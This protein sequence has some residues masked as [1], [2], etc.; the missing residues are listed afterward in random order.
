MSVLLKAMKRAAAEK[1]RMEGQASGAFKD[2]KVK[3]VYK[4]AP[5]GRKR[6]MIGFLLVVLGM[7]GIFIGALALMSGMFDRRVQRD[8]VVDV[9]PPLAVMASAK[10]PDV[11]ESF[12]EVFLKKEEA[13]GEA[14]AGESGKG[15]E[16]SVIAPLVVQVPEISPVPAQ[17]SF[18]YVHPMTQGPSRG[19]AADGNDETTQKAESPQKEGILSVR[20]TVIV[21]LTAHEPVPAVVV[22]ELSLPHVPAPVAAGVPAAEISLA[23]PAEKETAKNNDADLSGKGEL[24]LVPA[25]LVSGMAGALREI[26][27]TA[28][29]FGQEMSVDMQGRLSWASDRI[30]QEDVAQ[31]MSIYD[32]LRADYPE[33]V[34]ID[35]AQIMALRRFM[36]KSPELSILAVRLE[37]A[38]RGVAMAMV[39]D[40]ELVKEAETLIHRFMDAHPAAEII[41]S[42]VG[43]VLMEKGKPDVGLSFLEQAVQLAP[44]EPLH[45]YN[46]GVAQVRSGKTEEAVR[47]FRSALEM[48][49]EDFT[50]PRDAVKAWLQEHS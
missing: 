18:I 5:S 49:D 45:T 34:E 37:Q 16:A 1:G 19:D 30:R 38:A 13:S 22:P 21:P 10:S 3:S 24:P 14:E 33:R 23:V 25:G 50:F 2:I 6:H 20:D 28:A 17:P 7:A 40:P 41:A 12:S 11:S 36:P 44:K 46:L 26:P 48:G 43:G 42:Q 35:V 8:Q 29:R 27:W 4:S 31:A 32:G 9:P 39:D 47:L 15:E